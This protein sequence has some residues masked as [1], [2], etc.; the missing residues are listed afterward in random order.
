LTKQNFT[1]RVFMCR[2]HHSRSTA[3]FATTGFRQVGLRTLNVFF[4]T[5]SDSRAWRAGK[6]PARAR[7]ERPR[8]STPKPV[9]LGID[10]GRKSV[11]DSSGAFEPARSATIV[12]NT[13]TTAMGSMRIGGVCRGHRWRA[14]PM[15]SR[16]L[17]VVTDA[18]GRGSSHVRAE[19]CLSA[20]TLSTPPKSLR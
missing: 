2:I 13:I 6:A 12:A 1:S 10:R 14:Y 17:S 11:E 4:A 8:Q 16:R 7:L 3:C 19:R 15:S 20:S 5:I 18:Q 9:G